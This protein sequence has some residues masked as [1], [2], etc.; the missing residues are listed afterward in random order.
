MSSFLHVLCLPGPFMFHHVLGH[1]LLLL[2]NT[3]HLKAV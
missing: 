3:Y 1:G 2:L